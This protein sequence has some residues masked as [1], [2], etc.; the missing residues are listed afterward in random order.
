MVSYDQVKSSVRP[1]LK[2]G[3][4]CTCVCL[5]LGDIWVYCYVKFIIPSEFSP[6]NTPITEPFLRSL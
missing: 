3:V 2:G 6:W 5:R 1:K 4:V